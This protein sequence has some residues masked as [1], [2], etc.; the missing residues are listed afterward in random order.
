MIAIQEFSSLF[1]LFKK[2]PNE[3][4]CISHLEALRWEKGVVSPFDPE[5]KVYTLKN[6]RYKCRNT[7]KYF[8]VKTGTIFENT[9]IPLQK[10]FIALYL[11][12]SHKKGISSYQLARDL[13]ITQKS[14]W[15]MLSRI[16]T[17]F[18]QPDSLEKLGDNCEVVEADETFVGGKFKN[19]HSK[20]RRY[21]RENGIDNKAPVIGVLQRSF[22]GKKKVRAKAVPNVM[23][24][25]LA[26]FVQENVSKEAWFVSD[27]ANVY[28]QF[29]HNFR[30]HEYVNH[31]LGEYVKGSMFH[32]NNIENFWSH[33]KRGIFGIYHHVST[34]HL[35]KYVDEFVFRYN[36][37]NMKVAHRFNLFL[38][39]TNKRLRYKDLIMS[40]STQLE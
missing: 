20:E 31:H 6:H 3:S 14:A 7:N 21:L 15:F 12:L 36:T 5:S 34:K 17:A 26:P 35:Q 1:D 10:W 30:R 19:K 29:G 38:T 18:K 23:A 39:Q 40:K 13:D 4:S 24:E 25:N 32:T 27:G 9:K 37:M 33:L 8:N 16:R 28:Q 2:F 11:S 22:D